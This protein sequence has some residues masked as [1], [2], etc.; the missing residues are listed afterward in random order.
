[1]ATINLGR[2]KLV[3]KGVW[4]NSTTY[5]I[6]DFV[7]Y[8]DNGVVSTYIAV[9]AST[10]QTPSTS[11]TENSNFWK[12]LAKGVSLAVGNNK[13]VTSDGSGNLQGLSIG[14]AGQ[15]LKVNSSA[16]GYE[17]GSAGGVLQT[18]HAKTNTR[19]NISGSGTTQVT[20]LSANI[21]PSSASNKILVTVALYWGGGNNSYGSFRLRR[22]IGGTDT[23]PDHINGTANGSAVQGIFAA[24]NV[25][26]ANQEH[27]MWSG[28]KVG[29]DDN[30]NTTNQITYTVTMHCQG[31]AGMQMNRTHNDASN[32]NNYNTSVHST[33]TLQEVL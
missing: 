13:V 29:Y 19:Y 16:N 25:Q 17:F 7:Q 26:S 4:S 1:M 32:N 28:V 21:T 30:H 23:F 5:A 2:I 24:S 3:N 9:A 18:V 8:T 20:D 15:A 27:K 10:N 22:T 14:S 12:F 31:S 33:L 11:G 6:D